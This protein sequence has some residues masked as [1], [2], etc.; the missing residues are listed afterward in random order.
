MIRPAT[1]QDIPAIVE[2]GEKFHAVAG[3]DEIPW[4]RDDC[5]A[6]LWGFMQADCFLCFVAEERGQI[7]GMIAGV[8]SPV[9]FNTA[10]LSGEELFW[11][12]DDRAPLVGLRLLET[13]ERAAREHGCHTWQMKSLARLNGEAMGRLY[14]RRGYRACEQSYIKRL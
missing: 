6:S 14:E 2:L 10:H 8:M 5:E 9:Y 3:W 11:W 7:I 4:S 12:S 13:L 1:V